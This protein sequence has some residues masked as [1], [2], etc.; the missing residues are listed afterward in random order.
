M[1]KINISSCGYFLG[2]FPGHR[3]PTLDKIRDFL[4]QSNMLS[5]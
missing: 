3:C 2:L 5:M 4:P 1:V